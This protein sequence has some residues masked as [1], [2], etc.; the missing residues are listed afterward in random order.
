MSWINSKLD[1][2]E[3]DYINPEDWNRIESNTNE[4][5]TM[6]TNIQYTVPQLIIISNRDYTGIDFLSSI[7]RIENNIESLKD[8]F[9]TPPG[10]QDTK[11]WL[12]GMGFGYLDAIRLE[13]NLKLLYEWIPKVKDGFKYCGVYSCG[14]EGE[15]Y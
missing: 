11:T 2:A 6:L 1:W 3:E 12:L 4:V 5:A 13:N 14:E 10:Y 9:L 15:I 8:I 7:N